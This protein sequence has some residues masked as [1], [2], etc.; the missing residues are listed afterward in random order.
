[1]ITK[2]GLDYFQDLSVFELME[3]AKEVTEVGK[4]RQRIRAGNKNSR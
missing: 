2:T 3:M 1:M 4:E